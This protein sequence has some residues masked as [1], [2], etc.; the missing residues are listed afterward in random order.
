MGAADLY[1]QE[2]LQIGEADSQT[3]HVLRR[4]IGFANL[5][6]LVRGVGCAFATYYGDSTG[7]PAQL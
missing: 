7:L 6:S 3:L 1:Q 5:Q 4:A 2:A